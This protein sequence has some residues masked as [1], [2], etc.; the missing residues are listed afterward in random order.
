VEDTALQ[1][2]LNVMSISSFP[3]HSRRSFLQA[4]GLFSAA[5]ILKAAEPHAPHLQFPSEPQ[6]RLAVTSYP[7][8]AYIDSPT[9]PAR[10]K[11]KPGMDLKQFPAMMIERFKIYNI[12]PLGDHLAST[13]S[14]YLDAFR[15]AVADAGSHLVD[16]GLSGR[17]FATDA[18]P[19]RDEAVAYG[20][21]WIDIAAVLGSPS[22]RQHLKTSGGT[23]PSVDNAAQSLGRLAEY[24]AQKNV[25][26]NL[27]NDSP[28]AE[29]PFFIV[30]VVS[31]VNSPY[32]RALPDF[33]NS[34]RGHEAA[35]NRKAVDAM[36]QY[37]YNMCHVKDVLREKDGDVYRV[38]V[39]G[40][41]AV[42]RA[43]SYR[44]YFSMEFDTAAGDPFTGTAHLVEQSLKYM[45]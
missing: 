2:Q 34:G 17:D 32:L 4:T 6:Q 39:P 22:V 11:T 40:M 3:N 31:K 29:D 12:N 8:R 27:E 20:R 18:Q 38:D 9:N 7:F 28:G 25:I 10:D 1:K 26:V 41:F 44:G 13:D 36:F 45:G 23:A 24:G 33:G 30:A 14:A 15:K 19:I 16:L 5:M 42:A 43:H 35:Y 37:A 21:H